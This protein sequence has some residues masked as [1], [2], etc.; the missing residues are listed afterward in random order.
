MEG[1]SPFAVARYFIEKAKASGVEL[2]PMKLVK[3][4]Y[5]AHGWH[6]A[7]LGKPLIREPIQAWKYGPV[8]ESIYHGFKRLGNKPI[9]SDEAANLARADFSTETNALLQHV[10]NKYSTLT[11]LNLSALTHQPGTPWHTVWEREGGKIYRGE[12][13]PNEI[14]RAF[15]M[16]KLATATGSGH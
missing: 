5:I 12:V 3:L 15:Y 16:S 8:I 7:L 14:I 2:T 1:H 11:A 13:I 6:L 10:W 4:L 9:P